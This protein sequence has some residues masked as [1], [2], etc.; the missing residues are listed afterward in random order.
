MKK[1]QKNDDS[2]ITFIK[3][4]DISLIGIY[5]LFFGI[6]VTIIF[7]KIF[8]NN[9]YKSLSTINLIF[10]ILIHTTFLMIAVYIVRNIIYKI[11]FFLDGYYNYNHKRVKELNA[12][13]LISFSIISFQTFYQDEIKYLLKYH[14]NIL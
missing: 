10:N 11:P 13:I 3:C 7:K 6:L 8:E 5:Y 1:K 2:Y 4:I 9:N 12:N 14:F